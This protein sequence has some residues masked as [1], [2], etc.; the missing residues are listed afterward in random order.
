MFI[1][2]DDWDGSRHQF[3]PQSRDPVVHPRYNGSIEHCV[4]ELRLDS[5]TTQEAIAQAHALLQDRR[6]VLVFGE[7]AHPQCPCH[8]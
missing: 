6:V 4:M 3:L 7:P 1:V 8:Q 2:H 5:R